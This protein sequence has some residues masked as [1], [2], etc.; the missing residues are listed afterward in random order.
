MDDGEQLDLTVGDRVIVDTYV[1][2]R[3]YPGGWRLI[4]E[5]AEI[6]QV[7][8]VT[9]DVRLMKWSRRMIIGWRV[10]KNRVRKR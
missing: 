1:R 3:G 7:N 6:L 4:S 5:E 8:R 9:V 10:R 2:G